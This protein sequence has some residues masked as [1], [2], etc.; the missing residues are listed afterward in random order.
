MSYIETVIN[1]LI[2]L[3]SLLSPIED[4]TSEQQL[5]K[6]VFPHVYIVPQEELAL[7]VCGCPCSIGGSYLFKRYVGGIEA[8][9]IVMGGIDMDY[10]FLGHDV[11]V[12]FPD[13]PNWNSTLFHELQHHRQV[14]A[15]DLYELEDTIKDDD[16]V[17]KFVHQYMEEEAYMVQNEYNKMMGLPPLEIDYHTSNSMSWSAGE[18]KCAPGVIPIPEEER[19]DLID[20]IEFYDEGM[21]KVY[22]DK[23]H[24]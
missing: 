18:S 22:T 8:H 20:L 1:S 21:I 4:F 17:T 19:F 23:Y 3:L 16:E 10:H 7:S 11:S 2:V 12:V 9:T 5:A 24:N 15:Y 14:L 13:T 6:D